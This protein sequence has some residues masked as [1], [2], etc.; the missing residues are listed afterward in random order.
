MPM[1]GASHIPFTNR[2]IAS[3]VLASLSGT[4]LWLLPDYV[5]GDNQLFGSN[6]TLLPALA[7]SFI[8]G[9]SVLDAVGAVIADHAARRAE[10]VRVGREAVYGMLLVTLLAGLFA[11]SLRWIGYAP[12]SVLLVLALLFGTGGRNAGLNLA[13]SVS[14]AAVLYVAIRYG[15]G[16]H[17]Q[18]WPNLTG[19]GG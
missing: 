1:R 5:R 19:W 2:S 15:L 14:A 4:A 10:D 9:L 6:G 3:M 8:C 13:I 11:L 12:A 18:V 17:L 16:V 7:L